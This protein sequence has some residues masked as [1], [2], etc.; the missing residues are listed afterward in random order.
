MTYDSNVQITVYPAHSLYKKPSSTHEQH[1]KIV[2]TTIFHP[3]WALLMEIQ[4]QWQPP[5][6]LVTLF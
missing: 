6:S 5:T 4:A 2:T 1:C 3:T